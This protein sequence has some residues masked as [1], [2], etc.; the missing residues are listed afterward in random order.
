MP[1]FSKIT[2]NDAKINFE[3]ANWACEMKTLNEMKWTA[4]SF[5]V[6]EKCH[7][8]CALINTNL[9]FFVYDCMSC[10]GRNNLIILRGWTWNKLTR[11]SIGFYPP[12]KMIVQNVGRLFDSLQLRKMMLLTCDELF[13]IRKIRVTCRQI[14]WV[15]FK[16]GK[17]FYLPI[18]TL[19]LFTFGN[20][21]FFIVFF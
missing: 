13:V 6:L 12:Q 1:D 3:W 14:R 16:C 19:N 21:S 7:V 15:C 17:K 10:F 18:D 20:F 4:S 8:T 5:V 11:K 9:I 2:I